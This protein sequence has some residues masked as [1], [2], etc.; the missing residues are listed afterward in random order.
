MLLE[1]SLE[2]YATD[3]AFFQAANAFDLCQ[4]F[5]GRPGWSRSGSENI[6]VFDA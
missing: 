6:P 5:Q 1:S 3:T 4:P 2:T